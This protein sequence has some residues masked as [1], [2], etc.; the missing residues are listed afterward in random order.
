M[1][2]RISSRK[3]RAENPLQLLIIC[4]YGSSQKQK[5]I[6][7]PKWRKLPEL[8]NTKILKFYQNIDFE[9]ATF[10][11]FWNSINLDLIVIQKSRNEINF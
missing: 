4:D 9:A 10:L 2:G 1:A 7:A 5:I 11:V 3:L 6:R 8:I